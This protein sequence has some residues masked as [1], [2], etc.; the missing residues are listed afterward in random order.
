[1]IRR[2]IH[3][4]CHGDIELDDLSWRVIDTPQFQRLRELKQ[5]GTAY[6]VF[7]GATHNRFEHSL[8][9]GYL[10]NQLITRFQQQQPELEINEEDVTAITL[11]GLCHDLGHGP[12][13][14]LFDNSFI[15]KV[16]PGAS[17]SHEDASQ[18]MLE[19]LIDDNHIEEIDQHQLK[20]IQRLIEGQER[21]NIQGDRKYLYEIV[22]NK[23]NA[24]D[25][26][27]FDYL[28]RDCLN[29]GIKSSYDPSRLMKNSQ[30]I[31]NEICYQVKEVFNIY[32]MFHTR[33]SLFKRM[34]TH[35]ICTAVELMITDVLVLA[36]STLQLSDAIYDK[37]R[38]LFMTDGVLRDIEKSTE[39]SLED[40]RKIIR[41]LRVRDLYKFADEMLLDTAHKTDYENRITAAQIACVS[42][43]YKLDEDDVR[44]S[45]SL[46]NYGMK[47]KNPVDKIRFYNKYREAEQITDHIERHNTSYLVPQ[48]YAELVVRVY[49]TDPSKAQNV[50][51]AFRQLMRQMDSQATPIK[52]HTIPN[53]HQFTSPGKSPHGAKSPFLSSKKRRI[54]G[55]SS[56]GD[57]GHLDRPEP[58]QF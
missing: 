57:S 46:C 2:A 26:D 22:A 40:A 31:D 38:Y 14:H 6:Y 24:V 37:E 12:F 4:P 8:G 17:W 39:D 44:V 5:L 54:D 34:Y 41:R 42:S 55:T 16:K 1:M 10:A 33:Y 27:K 21:E 13:S 7:P 18:M 48:K 3:D 49:A 28:L 47:D 43:E 35:R 30:V 45:I 53:N 19:Y 25:V 56:A 52:L 23:T 50:Q 20:F 36:D 29:V 15:P 32:E 58:L 9:V 11:A 51:R